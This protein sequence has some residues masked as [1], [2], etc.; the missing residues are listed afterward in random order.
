MLLPLLISILA[1]SRTAT[2]LNVIYSNMLVVFLR[3]NN[4]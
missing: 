1:L 4:T 2:I 3:G